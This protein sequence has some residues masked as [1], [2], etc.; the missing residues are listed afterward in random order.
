MEKLNDLLNKL[1]EEIGDDKLEAWQDWEEEL[2]NFALKQFTAN[3]AS[4]A[5]KAKEL[6]SKYSIDVKAAL[7]ETIINTEGDIEDEVADL[8]E[9]PKTAAI[10]MAI[11]LLK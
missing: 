11:H 4:I 9:Y 2:S 5:A 3:K 10:V 1:E 7:K 6:A 8:F